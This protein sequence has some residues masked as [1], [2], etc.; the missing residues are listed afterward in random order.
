MNLAPQDRLLLRRAEIAAS[1]LKSRL[2]KTVVVDRKA[3]AAEMN[4]AFDKLD[5]LLISKGWP[6]TSD[7]WRHQVRR[8]FESGRKQIVLRVGRRGGKSSTLCRIGVIEALYGRHNVQPGDIGIVAIISQHRDEAAQRIRTIKSIL[9]ALGETYKPIQNGIRL[10]SKDVG[11]KVY[12]ASVAGVSGFTSICILCD[13]VAKWRDADTGANPAK[14][15]LA[16][17]RPTMATMPL[18]KI[19]L[20]SSPMGRLDAHATAFDKGDDDFQW[21]AFA[22]TWDANPTISE[23]DT[24]ALERDERRRRREYGAEPTDETEFS[25]LSAIMLNKAQRPDNEP[26]PAEMGNHYVASMDP[27]FTRNAWT[28]AITSRRVVGAVVKRSVVFINEWRGSATQPLDPKVVLPEILAYCKEYDL[29]TVYTDQ[30]ER[31]SLNSIGQSIGL[32]V[33]AATW[34]AADKL[35]AYESL[36]T[37]FANGE[38]DIPPDKQL[39]ADLLGIQSKITAN[40][41]T[42]KLQETGDGRHCDYAP[43]VLLGLWK[44]RSAPDEAPPPPKKYV[45]PKPRTSTDWAKMAQELEEQA[46]QKVQDVEED[47]LDNF[48]TKYG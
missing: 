18:A 15:V 17:V 5:A 29:D 10:T 43:A 20:S 42:I 39:R 25:L 23:A 2:A 27:G 32:N 41:F 19:L 7:W 40:G 30:Y 16:S 37:W 45:P 35:G 48:A 14:E 21:T 26:V 36:E 12:T 3:Y 31:F 11:F 6:R 28:F 4:A 33:V 34:T 13:E 47:P 24:H 8:Y 9:D 46:C 44:A 1:I 22:T 38:V